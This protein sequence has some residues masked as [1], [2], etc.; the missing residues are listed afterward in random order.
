[1]SLRRESR[2]PWT[3]APLFAV[4]LAVVWVST[5]GAVARPD[6]VFFRVDDQFAAIGWR[7]ESADE[8]LPPPPPGID[9]PEGVECDF[10]GY[11]LWMREVWKSPDASPENFSLVREYILGETNPEAS[12]YWHF[13]AYWAEEIVCLQWVTADSC[14]EDYEV[15]GVR[16]DSA[17]MFHN[18]FPYE[19]SV[20]AFST[21]DP[22][23]VDYESIDANRT[24]VVYPRAGVRSGLSAV[25]CIP[26]PY[27]A[28]ADWEYGGQRRV[29]FIGLPETATIMIY[30][31]SADHV[32]TL[33]HQDAES[34]LEFWDLKNKDGEEI[35]PGVYMYQVESGGET[36]EGKVMI[37]K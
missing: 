34:D 31:V 1:M 4:L 7:M 20:T 5:A 37:I 28:A 15:E 23:A 32:R 35:A 14:H 11:R 26:N 22:Q 2:N 33:R 18:A 12:G 36:A 19:F 8:E 10:G 27:R 29:T 30:T 21:N 6:I 13:P 24:G 9:C 3:V 17:A 25:R 16:R